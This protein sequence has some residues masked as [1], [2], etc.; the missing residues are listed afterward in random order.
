MTIRRIIAAAFVAVLSLTAIAA[1]AAH[2]AGHTSAKKDT[3][4]GG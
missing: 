2:A 3:Q 1:P 4:W